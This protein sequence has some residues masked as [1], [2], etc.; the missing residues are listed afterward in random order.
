MTKRVAI[1]VIHGIGEQIPMETLSGF[2]DAVWT[3]DTALVSVEKKHPDTGESRTGNAA[4]YKPDPRTRNFDLRLITTETYETQAKDRRRADF[5]E[6]YWAHRITGTQFDQVR[7][8]IFG[9]MLRNPRK[10]VPPPLLPAWLAMWFLLLIGMAIVVVANRMFGGAAMALA[11]AV[12]VLASSWVIGKLN[13]VVGD[14]VRYVDPSPRNIKTR[15][16]I[17]E[18][19]VRLL[20]TL[21]GVDDTGACHGSDYDRVI[22]AGHSLGTIVGYDII[23]H[24]FGRLNLKFDRAKLAAGDQGNMEA[25][26]NLVRTA[27]AAGK[28]LVIDKYQAAQDRARRELNAAGHPWIVSDFVS[29]GSPLTHAE[30]LMARDRAHLAKLKVQRVYPTCPP[31][32]EFDRANGQHRFTYAATKAFPGAGPDV[33]GKRVPHHAAG[34]AFTRWTNIQ[35]PLRFIVGGDIVSGPVCE[36]FGLAV[37]AA[38]AQGKGAVR[39]ICGIDEQAVLPS[40][41]GEPADRKRR[42]LTHRQYWDMRI[43]QTP[44][45]IARHIAVLRRALNL[46][47]ETAEPAT[48]D[49]SQ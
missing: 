41:V 6:F 23:S 40:P 19:G 7:A 35:S 32:L 28:P 17:R 15:Q 45:K 8:W 31:Q 44:G 24:A 21:M 22:V 34:F 3:T 26:E 42:F 39:S 1:V 49:N 20:E 29:I 5:F 16:E 2:I 48:K 10:K 25:L 30:F 27:W 12:Y 46:A 4:W 36:A 18:D 37:S 47:E 38:A 13:A 9:L 43:A 33:A 11:S 14:I